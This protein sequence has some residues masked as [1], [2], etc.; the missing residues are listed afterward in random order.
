MVVSHAQIPKS[1]VIAKLLPFPP[2][3]ESIAQG[4]ARHSFRRFH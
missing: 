4:H 1:L 3:G 2:F